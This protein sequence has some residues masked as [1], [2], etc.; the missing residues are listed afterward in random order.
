[1]FN[2]GFMKLTTLPIAALVTAIA[3]CTTYENTEIPVERITTA[4][5]LASSPDGAHTIMRALG[6]DDD[7]A[8]TQQWV[9]R[10]GQS[11]AMRIFGHDADSI[12]PSLRQFSS[13]IGRLHRNMASILPDAPPLRQIYATVIPYSQSVIL[14]SDTNGITIIVGLNHYLGADYEGYSSFPAYRRAR[15]TPEW[16]TR[17]IA[18]AI[19]RTVYPLES[20]AHPTL[21]QRMLYEGAV[22]AALVR[23]MPDN[24]ARA[25]GMT[26]D[27]FAQ[28]YRS[29][30]EIWQRMAGSDLLFDRSERT[31]SSL[32]HE[33]SP[34]TVIGRDVPPMA[35]RLTGWRIAESYLKANPE[36]TPESLLQPT[37]YLSDKTLRE[38]KYMP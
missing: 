4:E 5:A 7:T 28:L 33:G 14:M 23:L 27:D 11:E 12:M 18:E 37:F 26:D 20:D 36:A 16:M 9:Y 31:A 13:D 35:G 22:A 15:K 32:L 34:G 2:F 1:L 19:V 38:A 25:I 24:E 8:A 6:A 17:D 30:K 29:E 3:S 21:L 10:F